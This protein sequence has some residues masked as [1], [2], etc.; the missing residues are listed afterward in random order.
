M[1]LLINGSYCLLEID[2]VYFGSKIRGMY[3]FH[4][5]SIQT[6]EVEVF[7]ATVDKCLQTSRRHTPAGDSHHSDWQQ[8]HK[9]RCC[10]DLPNLNVCILQSQFYFGL[11]IVLLVTFQNLNISS[12]CA[13]CTYNIVIKN[14]TVAP[15]CMDNVRMSVFVFVSFY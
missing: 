11:N 14:L 6:V 8:S 5:Y 15:G 7:I 10:C 4:V 1:F 2:N 3:N 12:N 9:S 13:Y